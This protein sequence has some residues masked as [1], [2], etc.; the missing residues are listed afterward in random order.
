MNTSTQSE[1][2]LENQLI[3]QLAG[4]GY[5]RVSIPH[6]AAM[7]ENLRIQLSN[8][9]DIALKGVPL[10]ANEIKFIL[11]YLNQ[12]TIYERAQRLRDLYPLTRDDGTK[13]HIEFLNTASWCKN[14]YQVTNQVSTQGKY[15]NRYDVTILIN[16]LPLVQIELKK[17]GVELKKAFHQI[18][19]YQHD[20]YDGGYG[21]FQYVQLFIISNGVNTRYFANGNGNKDRKLDDQFTFNWTDEQ[22]KAYNQLSSF[23]EYF[24]KVC[25]V[26]KMITH[27]MVL[28]TD[29]TI[30]V[31][32]P[33]QFYAVENIIAHVKESKNNG[34]IWHTTGSGKT[35]T[36]FKASKVINEEM[37]GVVQKILFVV[38]RKDLDDQTIK[39]FNAFEDGCVDETTNT[40][41]LVRK[42]K[43]DLPENRLIVTTL[44][45]LNRAIKHEGFKQHI[46]HLR[47][48][49]VLF[50]FDECHR[51][52][53]GETH[54]NIINFFVNAQL[55]GFT[56]T[57]ILE[58]NQHKVG[59]HGRTTANLFDG[60]LHK[61]TIMDAIHDG[62]V[63][64]FMVEYQETYRNEGDANIKAVLEA[65]ERLD[66]IVDYVLEHHNQK[67]F[68]HK[69]KDHF[70][71]MFCVSNVPMLIE[72]YE[73]FKE[74]QKGLEKPLKIAAIFSY[75]EN[76]ARMDSNAD[77]M[78]VNNDELENEPNT[79]PS[80][81][82]KLE[83][84]I[85]DYNQLFKTNYSTKDNKFD[86]YYKDIS[87]RVKKRE[88]DLLLVVNMFLTGF[89]S[90]ALNTLYVDKNL[91]YHGLIQAYSRTNRLCGG[92]KQ[93][94]NIVAFRDLKDAT[95]QAIMLFSNKD[96]QDTVLVRPY[97]HYVNEYN[98]AVATLLKITPT[99]DAVD[100]LRGEEAQLKFV[101]SF[102]A[103]MR[104]QAILV[105]FA[106]H[107]PENLNLDE[108][109]FEDYK[110]K[111]LDIRDRVI[112]RP[113]PE[114]E[115]ILDHV[116]FE[117]ELIQTDLINVD[118]IL[119]LLEQLNTDK[120]KG[121][122]TQEEQKRREQIY[123][124]IET[125][126]QLRNKEPLLKEFM[127]N[128]DFA[129][130]QKDDNLKDQFAN[131]WNEKSEEA[132]KR[133]CKKE[134]LKL[135]GENG[136]KK[137]IA[138]FLYHKRMPTDDEIAQLID[139]DV[140]IL[141]REAVFERISQKVKELIEIF[142]EN[143]L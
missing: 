134:K 111:Y 143:M 28:A 57:P 52:Q 74:K 50:I 132:A 44:Q 136:L 29:K 87:N 37:A 100:D 92:L 94:G 121:M 117:L 71:A 51:S 139:Y 31:L 131:F 119:S 91:K 47:D 22:N 124:L 122:S 78:G 27:Y 128:Y 35:L 11:T 25:H 10:S 67:T 90:P 80:Y 105:T 98:H 133:L 106:K 70:T 43:S 39:E 115:S 89:D 62:N 33:Y 18:Q 38:D 68:K 142:Y 103:L 49:K 42:L 135:E 54:N 88:I 66:N 79:D 126:P 2:A 26:S 125:T 46:E 56:G 1:S 34:Y 69:V 16:G 116:D 4:M 129:L 104:L 120:Q 101:E 21:L 60:C 17:R 19:R 114:E 137:V 85:Q 109:T 55:I 112:H 123:K 93:H 84:F 59:K 45:K 6:D 140:D 12:G 13:V 107:K 138:N 3:T 48:Q 7:V 9:N 73:R 72:Y 8:H 36:S 53:F 40:S 118:Y 75:D 58:K 108:Q 130:A 110:S 65:P 30:R 77:D 97:E 102:R 95:D 96:A 5:E 141:E 76:T 64:P 81:R 127:A 24:L 61:Y 83:G 20:S 23:A 14:E 113:E 32:R 15:K 86:G 63:L 82:D 41:S 99:I